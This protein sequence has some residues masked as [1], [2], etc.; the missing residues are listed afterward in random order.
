V[1]K[2]PSD[3]LAGALAKIEMGLRIQ[4]PH[5]GEEGAWELLNGGFRE[6]RKQ[7]GQP[8]TCEPRSRPS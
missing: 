2:T 8:N 3:S 4:E 7:L 6:L 1:A 5:D